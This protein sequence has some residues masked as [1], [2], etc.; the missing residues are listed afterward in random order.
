MLEEYCEIEEQITLTM[1]ALHACE[2]VIQNK[3]IQAFCILVQILRSRLY[4]HSSMQNVQ[5][6]P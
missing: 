4:G 6:C 5:I 1:V 3:I 2:N